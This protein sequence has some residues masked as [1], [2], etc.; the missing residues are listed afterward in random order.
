VN[1]GTSGAISVRNAPYNGTVGAN[2]ST[3]FGY[4]VNGG[5]NAA[6]SNISCTSS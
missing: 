3:S 4:V 2:A 6:P 5:S 1:T